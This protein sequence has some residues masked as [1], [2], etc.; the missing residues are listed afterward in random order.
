MCHA[1][2]GVAFPCTRPMGRVHHPYMP[3]TRKSLKI[4]AKG[5]TRRN[6]GRH[7]LD[8]RPD[9]LDFRDRMFESTLVEVPVRRPLDEYRAKKVP[10][11][12]Q[13]Q[14]GAC[15]GYG[16]ATVVHYL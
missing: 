2:S 11:L 8:A 5:K 6:S 4:A 13:G 10:I 3:T 1:H 14:E 7:I 9:T 12:D 15:T 16:L